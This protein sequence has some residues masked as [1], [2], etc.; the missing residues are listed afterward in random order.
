MTAIAK[1]IGSHIRAFP[2]LDSASITA[3]AGNDNVAVNGNIIDLQAFAAQKFDSAKLIV[4]YK[5]TLASAQTLAIAAK[6]QDG[7]A[8][9][10][11]DG[12]DYGAQLAKTVFET[13]VVT[14]KYGTA[15]VAIDLS[16]A[17]RY[18]RATVTADLSAGGTDTVVVAA[19]LVLG[20]AQRIP[21]SI[22]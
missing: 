1:D 4:L 2:A 3:G 8:S 9:N 6:L 21:V 19:V 20:G 14:G 15:E 22:P 17:R 7:A 18:V 11:S 16:G 13:G 5:T 10:L 12:Q